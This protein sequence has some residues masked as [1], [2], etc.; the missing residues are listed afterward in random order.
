MAT[1]YKR[2]ALRDCSFGFTVSSCG[3]KLLISTVEHH[4]CNVFVVIKLKGM[5]CV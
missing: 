5:S 2:E 1:V 4:C 3:V